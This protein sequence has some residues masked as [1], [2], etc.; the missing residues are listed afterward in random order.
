MN[1]FLKPS[2]FVHAIDGDGNKVD[3]YCKPWTEV[4]PVLLKEPPGTVKWYFGDMNCE[5]SKETAQYL[6]VS[7]C[8]D[9]E[10]IAASI[11]VWRT[12]HDNS[13]LSYNSRQAIHK[14]ESCLKQR[15]RTP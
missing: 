6:W 4:M 15:G 1:I 12:T 3:Q 7:L 11:E 14:L 10:L 9:E 2:G 13:N 5:I 8:R